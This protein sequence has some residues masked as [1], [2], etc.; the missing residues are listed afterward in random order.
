MLVQNRATSWS[1]KK[2][3]VMLFKKKIKV[4]ELTVLCEKKEKGEKEIHAANNSMRAQLAGPGFSES[5]GRQN[6]T[7]RPQ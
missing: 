3:Q 2:K 5:G 6:Q 4:L 1:D 7:G